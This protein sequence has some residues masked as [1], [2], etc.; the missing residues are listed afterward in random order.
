MELPY[1]QA[2]ENTA[3]TLSQPVWNIGLPAAYFCCTMI[4]Y[5]IMRKC[6]P[7][8][9]P[10]WFKIFY[11]L[12]QVTLSLY[13]LIF[14]M[15]V[16]SDIL[17]HP[18]GLNM[19]FNGAHSK[20]LHYCVCVHFLSK[21]LDY[22]D[23]LLIVVNKKDTQ[24][25]VLHV[26][27]HCSI[28]AVWGYLIHGGYADGT[29]AFGAWI[30]ALVHSIMYTYY[31]LTAAKVNTKPLKKWVTR[32]QLTQFCLCIIHAIVVCLFDTTLPSY[33]PWLQFF[34]HCTMI[35]LFGQFYMKTYTKKGTGR[36]KK[37]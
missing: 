24:L 33:L 13:C 35:A 12:C 4:G 30:N 2:L 14:G 26:Y 3:H 23:T 5:A 25:S 28:S 20:S 36:H 29:T 17:A 11:N 16:M 27:H 21:F 19:P 32:V 1:F 10:T 7:F 8:R 37:E 18:F 34:Y 22:V 31:G 6:N 9:T 15:P